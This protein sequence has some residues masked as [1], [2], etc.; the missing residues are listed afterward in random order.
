LALVISL[1]RKSSAEALASGCRSLHPLDALDRWATPT[2]CS[3]Q[4]GITQKQ[5]T[6]SDGPIAQ[7]PRP[8]LMHPAI[9]PVSQDIE[10]GPAQPAEALA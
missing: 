4:G 3:R 2:E 5:H 10:A 7:N 1:L 9:D 8:P 6:E